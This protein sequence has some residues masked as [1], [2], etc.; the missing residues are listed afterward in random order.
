ML[1]DHDQKRMLKSADY[2]VQRIGILAENTTA[3]VC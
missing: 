3:T 1:C 2:T